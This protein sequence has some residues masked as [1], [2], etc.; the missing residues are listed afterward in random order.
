MW[1]EKLAVVNNGHSATGDQELLEVPANI[2][3][4]QTLVCQIVFPGEVYGRW[5][6]VSLQ[7]HVRMYEIL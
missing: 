1:H 7:V 4:L 3:R 5:W 6:T 2:V